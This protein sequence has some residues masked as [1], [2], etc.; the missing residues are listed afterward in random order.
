MP[1]QQEPFD[2]DTIT[3]GEMLAVERA[4]GEEFMDLVRSRTG[5]LMV[6]LFLRAFRQ[7]GTAPPWS[8]IADQRLSAR[9]S[10][11]SPTSP[12]GASRT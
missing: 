1:D 2:V 7:Q 11:A 5:L 4:S 6:V 3:L 9:L 12:D 10:S 8:E